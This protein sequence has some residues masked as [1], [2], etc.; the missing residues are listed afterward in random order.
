M[1][2]GCV[3]GLMLTAAAQVLYAQPAEAPAGPTTILQAGRV[4]PPVVFQK[5]ITLPALP[6]PRAVAPSMLEASAVVWVEGGLILASDKHEHLLF[7]LPFDPQTLAAGEPIPLPVVYSDHYLLEDL[8]AMALR[9]DEQGQAWVYAMSSLSNAP[10]GVALPRRRHMLRARI[11]RTPEGAWQAYESTVADVSPLRTAFQQEFATVG[12]APYRTFHA[13]HLEADKNTYRWGN[14]EGLAFVPQSKTGQLMLGFRN[15]LYAGHAMVG[16]VEQVDAVFDSFDSQIVLK[17]IFALDLGG[18]G[19]SDM[20]W[21]PVTKGYLIAGL[22]SSG[23]K[24][25]DDSPFPPHKLGSALFWWSGH[26]ADTP[27]RFADAPDMK[28]EGVCRIGTTRLIAVVSDEADQSE[29]RED[30]FQSILT[31]LDFRGVSRPSPQASQGLTP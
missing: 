15:P 26:K 18:R 6:M 25:D 13:A 14:V 17:D 11:S 19:V 12:V 10:N 4:E 3:W 24:L 22:R 20:C 30:S 28:I 7:V 5:D 16:V 1:L 2:A 27:I 29:G 31:V 21:D 8:E 23:P 9:M